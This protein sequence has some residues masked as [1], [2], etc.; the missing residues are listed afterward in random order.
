MGSTRAASCRRCCCM[1]GHFFGSTGAVAMHGRRSYSLPASCVHVKPPMTTRTKRSQT[2]ITPTHQFDQSNQRCS[3]AMRTAAPAST[4][5][6]FV[7]PKMATARVRASNLTQTFPACSRILKAWTV[8][9]CRM[10][11]IGQR[12]AAMA[13][14]ALLPPRPARVQPPT[15]TASSSRRATSA[16]CRPG[17]AASS[18]AHASCLR[19]GCQNLGN[20]SSSPLRLAVHHQH[21]SPPT[22]HHPALKRPSCHT[23]AT[24]STPGRCAPCK[25][26]AT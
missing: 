3:L 2:Q 12:W 10:L 21:N 1:L 20:H 19:W 13:A 24:W 25:S 14:L 26:T 7:Q 8:A 16:H 15:T 6:E 23:L 5:A 22:P 9:A 4:A 17:S 18:M 11:C